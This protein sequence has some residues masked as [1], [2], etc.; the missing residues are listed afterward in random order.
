MPQQ[1]LGFTGDDTDRGGGRS[2]RKQL[3][4]VSPQSSGLGNLSPGRTASPGSPSISWPRLTPQGPSSQSVQAGG[5]Q[6]CLLEK[7]R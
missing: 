4:T 1:W 6:R 7:G 2:G 3:E 5:P